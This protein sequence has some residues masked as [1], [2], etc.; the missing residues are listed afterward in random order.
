MLHV[1][2]CIFGSWRKDLAKQRKHWMFYHVFGLL[3]T[4]WTI[5]TICSVNPGTLQLSS[6]PNARCC[7]TTWR[8]KRLAL[9]SSWWKT[10]R[11]PWA[12]AQEPASHGQPVH[13]SCR[14]ALLCY[15]YINLYHTT[16]I[17][18]YVCIL[19]CI[20]ILYYI[21]MYMY[22]YIQFH[23]IAIALHTYMVSQIGRVTDDLL[24]NLAAVLL[25]LSFVL[26][27]ILGTL[28]LFISEPMCD[29]LNRGFEHIWKL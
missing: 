29:L 15:Y 11:C 2:T 22:T 1:F 20:V 12:G 23:A 10:W 7:C 26:Q 5:W 14:S 27:H 28:V 6:A 24:E 21:Y 9:N 19:Y 8:W 25:E 3:I 4:T 18:N 17:Y 13:Q 16:Y